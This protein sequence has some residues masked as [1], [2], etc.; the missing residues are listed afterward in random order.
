[1]KLVMVRH[2]RIAVPPG[3][4][5]GQTDVPV[6][7]T[8]P[9]EAAAVREK[10]AGWVPDRVYT[11]PLGRCVS[12]AGFCGYPDAVWDD[13]LKELHFGEWENHPWDELDMSVWETDWIGNPPP[14]GESFVQMYERVSGFLDELKTKS[15]NTALVFTHG[16]VINCARIYFGQNTFE[17]VFDRMSEYGQ[18]WEFEL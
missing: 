10:L 16:G 5:Y 15:I 9:E 3:I 2:T 6:Y 18:V 4:C 13:R 7:E 17:D 8:F 14:G 11:S 1:M 12:L